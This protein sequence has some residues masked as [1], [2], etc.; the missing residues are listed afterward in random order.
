MG[1]GG[2]GGLVTVIVGCCG[3]CSLTASLG[4]NS[5][6]NKNH[7]HLVGLRVPPLACNR[8]FQ[9]FKFCC[10]AL[11]VSWSV[12]LMA[13]TFVIVVSSMKVSKPCVIVFD[14]SRDWVIHGRACEMYARMRLLARITQRGPHRQHL[15]R[16]HTT[17][18]LLYDR[19]ICP[20]FQ[21]CA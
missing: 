14:W 15:G 4:Q 10:A 5:Q 1:W 2:L 3:W 20:K 11:T 8:L 18:V 21:T 7:M 16:L 17:G 12:S 6:L 9:R 19:C 13:A